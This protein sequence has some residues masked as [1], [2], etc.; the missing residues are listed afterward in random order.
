M[1]LGLAD[2]KKRVVRRQG[3]AYLVPQLLRPGEVRAELDALIGLFESWV[4]RERD[5]F[6][7]DRPAELLGDYRLARGLATVLSEWYA[8]EPVAWPGPASVGEAAALAVREITTPSAIRL[9]L[10]DAVSASSGGFLAA[11][12]READLNAFA[13]SLDLGRAT[14]DALLALDDEGRARLAR[15]TLD[16]PTPAALAARYNQRA[17]EAMLTSA[18]S[19]E[20]VIPPEVA[21]AQGISLGTLL[22][23][24]CFLA[25]R[26]GVFYDVA[27][28]VAS[29]RAGDEE[30]PASTALARVAETRNLY[31]VPVAADQP[32]DAMNRSLVVT[33]F[34]PQEAF[35]GPTLYGDRLAQL[36]R[37]LLGNRLGLPRPAGANPQPP[38]LLGAGLRGEARVYL[39]GQP[40]RFALDER[41]LKLLEGRTK[42]TAA[43]QASAG[44]EPSF[45][46]TLEQRLHDEFAA[47]VRADGARGWRLEREPEPILVGATILIPDFA[48]TRGQRRVYLE[49]AGYWSPAYRERKR[50]KLAALA[51]RV[52]LIVA[53][54]EAARA[55][56]AGVESSFPL[57]WYRDHVSA[58]ALINLLEARYDDFDERRASVQAAEVLDEVG[59]RGLLPW[60]ECAGVL[61]TYSRTE[62]LVVVEDIVQHASAHDIAPPRLI[63]GVGLAAASWLDRA[64]AA[65]GRWVDASGEQGLALAALAERATEPPD[66]LVHQD[67]GLSGAEALAGAAGFAVVRASI[68]EPRVVRPRAPG[69]DPTPSPGNTP[70]RTAAQPRVPHRRTHLQRTRTAADAPPSLWQTDHPGST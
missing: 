32:L 25:R 67:I 1:R 10:Y 45:D 61:R 5:A 9:A 65:I 60:G 26:L 13:A 30:Q 43:D 18:A 49:V 6:P 62:L 12:D 21:T 54:P 24:V 52:A 33:L 44:A 41:L 38:S 47:L 58:Q 31:A 57:L 22:K 66:E 4:G 53:A 37:L 48:L 35:G 63:E 56:L 16:T 64:R 51:G 69:G 27:F 7:T 34:G 59:A 8:W 23:R 29:E 46:S 3:E 19:V 28:E 40:F 17:V 2:V 11:S 68:F 15:A 39:R 14:L 20:W 36:C 70:T 55:E 50:R 42:G